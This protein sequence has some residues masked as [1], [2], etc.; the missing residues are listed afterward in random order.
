MTN[1]AI[2]LDD[3]TIAAIVKELADELD[4][5]QRERQPVRVVAS[6]DAHELVARKVAKWSQK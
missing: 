4:R 3:N 2:K 5:R 6:N 1:P